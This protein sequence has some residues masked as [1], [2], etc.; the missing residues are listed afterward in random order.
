MKDVLIIGAGPAGL[1]AAIY[2]RR[3]GLSVGIVEKNVYGGQTAII[4]TIEN[5][6][7]FKK[8]S[9][10]EFSTLLHDQVKNLGAEFIF[11]QVSEVDFSGVEKTMVMSDGKIASALTIIVANG[12]KRRKLGCRGE[13]EFLGR[14]VSYCAT[15]DG[16]F[17][18]DKTV[19]VVGG[20]NTALEDS[21]Y[22]SNICK[23][24]ILAVRKG[25]FRA[26]KTLSDAVFRRTN[27]D[28]KFNTCVKEIL[29][30]KV[31][32]GVVLN[33]GESEE[34][35]VADGVFIAIG[36]QPDNEIFRNKID[37]NELGYFIAGE[38]CN[39]NIPGVFVAGDCRVKPLRQ[40]AT[41][42]SDGAV[43]G[44]AAASYVSALVSANKLKI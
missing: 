2:A 10:F 19:I 34:S 12:L 3:A 41:A 16:A 7:G 21:L 44:N 38:D 26:E 42:V 33:C 17:F 27:I 31:V 14:G 9:G 39:T 24:V 29:G 8:I 15:C 13:D 30:E 4:D 28:V 25:N 40:I 22:L 6:P 37:M 35:V 23:K 43:A 36:Y 5:Y 11:N 18:K 32:N 20:G 1:T